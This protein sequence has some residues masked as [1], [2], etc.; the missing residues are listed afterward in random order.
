MVAGVREVRL[1]G[2]GAWIAAG[3]HVAALGTL[4]GLMLGGE[5]AGASGFVVHAAL[6]LTAFGPVVWAVRRAL[7]GE[8]RS[9]PGVLAVV[10]IAGAVTRAVFLVGPPVLSGDLHRA[11][12]EGQVVAAG[13]DPWAQPPDHPGLEELR[14]RLPEIRDDVEYWMLPAIWPPGA[15]WFAAAVTSLAPG[16]AAMRGMLKAGFVLAEA[17]LIAALILLLRRRGLD[18]LLV[19][20]WVWNPLA[21]VEIAGSG[22]G[23]ALGVALVGLALAAASSGR[24]LRAAA[25]AG[26]SGS[27]KFAGL[28]LVP[29]LVM[30]RHTPLSVRTGA[31]SRR[32][33]EPPPGELGRS[34]RKQRSM[35]SR[36]RAAVVAVAGVAMAIPFAPLLAP[37]RVGDGVVARLGEL[38]FSLL[39]YARHWRFNESL[40]LPLEA[41]VG[42]LARPAALSGVLAVGAVLLLRRESPAFSMGALAAAGFLLSPVAHPWYLSWSLPFLLLH[43][44]RRGWFAG[45]LALSATSVLSYEPLWTT[46]PGAEWILPPGLRLAEYLAPAAVAWLAVRFSTGPAGGGVQRESESSRRK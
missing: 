28:A 33:G 34:I 40:F 41:A 13:L 19:A 9:G 45:V 36:A 46:P 14:E 12:W 26:L 22:H 20:A 35:R 18:P 3:F 30:E 1:G 24:V 23:D 38:G 37:E 5:L 10:L 44:E 15:Q 32:S 8:L 31:P 2:G 16:P 39:H 25:L 11:V 21:V 17:A 43:P 27:V 29:F 4:G 6:H 7:A 42:E